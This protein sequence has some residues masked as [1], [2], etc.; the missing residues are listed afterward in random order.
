MQM[1]GI[2]FSKLFGDDVARD[3]TEARETAQRAEIRTLRE[4]EMG[5]ISGGDGG[6]IF[7]TV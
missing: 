3:L 2:D 5:W 6:V 7:P 4:V 1:N